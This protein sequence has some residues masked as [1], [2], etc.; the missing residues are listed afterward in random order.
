VS[1]GPALEIIMRN[2]RK[3]FTLVELLVAMALTI[4]MMAILSQ[5]FVIAIDVFSGLKGL[6][7]MQENLRA[8]TNALRYD[9]AQGHF[10]GAR[11]L[12]DPSIVTQRPQEGFLVVVHGA[13][14]VLEGN[15]NDPNG[16][17]SSRATN[18]VLQFA[19]R[20]KGNQ[21]QSFYSTQ[22]GNTVNN[23][24]TTFF[25]KQPFF[26]LQPAQAADAT[27]RDPTTNFFRSQWA[28]IAYYLKPIG[29]TEEPLNPAGTTGTKIFGLYRTQYVAVTDNTQLVG[30]FQNG[31]LVD[32][33]GVACNANGGTG[34]IDFYTPADL[35]TGTR[36]FNPTTFLANQA[37]PQRAEALV[38][39]NVLS[40]QVRVI[41]SG[42]TNTPPSDLP[43]PFPATYDTAAATTTTGLQGLA[44]TLRVWDNKTRQTRQQTLMLDL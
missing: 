1:G 12:S 19:A 29:T 38:L 27:L 13:A 21:Q 8:A 18:H 43:A 40:F 34:N 31:Q 25:A 11:R 10:E 2:I 30:Q 9:L 42:T 32:L 20:L 14:S 3:G 24:A 16:V 6:G 22:I 15:D 28:E 35:A 26:N 17:P 41:P 36:T 23:T 33:P 37:Q 39:P 5:A 4:F 7:D 44:I